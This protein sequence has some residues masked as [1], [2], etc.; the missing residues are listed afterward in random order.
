MDLEVD[1][2]WPEFTFSSEG[3]LEMCLTD[4][5]P[6]AEWMVDVRKTVV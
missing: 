3:R 6:D 2:D 1:C 4:L 5:P